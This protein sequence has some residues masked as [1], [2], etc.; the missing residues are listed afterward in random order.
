VA[1]RNAKRELLSEELKREVKERKRMEE[2][3][4]AIKIL[5]EKQLVNSDTERELLS[6]ELE[7]EVKERKRIDEEYRKSIPRYKAYLAAASIIIIIAGATGIISQQYLFVP[8]VASK[9]PEIV[10]PAV[11]DPVNSPVQLL[12]QPSQT[13]QTT[14]AIQPFV[15]ETSKQIQSPPALAQTV[16]PGKQSAVHLISPPKENVT[17]V[18]KKRIVCN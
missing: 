10:A 9:P 14:Q 3:L 2:E 5:L 13:P 15:P 17:V 4:R 7:R 18:E 8:K 16:M 1:N 12:E 6:E 11:Q